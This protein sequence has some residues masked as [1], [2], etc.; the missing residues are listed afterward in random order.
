MVWEDSLHRWPSAVKQSGT[1]FNQLSKWIKW[2]AA[3]QYYR[4]KKNAIL[5]I[6]GSCIFEKAHKYLFQEKS[7]KGLVRSKKEDSI[8]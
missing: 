6:Q 8:N 1:K 7:N 4:G 5:Q 3:E 2:I